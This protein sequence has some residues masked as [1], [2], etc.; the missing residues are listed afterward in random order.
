[1]ILYT[2]VESD[3]QALMSVPM[4][5]LGAGRGGGGGNL[6]RRTIDSNSKLKLTKY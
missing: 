4:R 5:Y 3:G 1:M 6:R 2:K